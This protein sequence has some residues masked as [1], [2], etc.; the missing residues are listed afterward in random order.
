LAGGVRHGV[1]WAGGVAVF[2]ITSTAF[3]QGTRKVPGMTKTAHREAAADR[4]N[5]AAKDRDMHVKGQRIF[6]CEC[7]SPYTAENVGKL[8]TRHVYGLHSV[9][10]KM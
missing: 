9:A 1:Q 8:F 3:R 4:L 7:G 2:V 10:R 5:R 6:G